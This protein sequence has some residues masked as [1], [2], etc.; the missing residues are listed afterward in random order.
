[1]AK[2]N[3]HFWIY[4]ITTL[5]VIYYLLK[6]IFESYANNWTISLIS[7]TILFFVNTISMFYTIAYNYT[8]YIIPSWIIN[9]VFIIY[10][11]YEHKLTL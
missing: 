10:L 2:F 6:K 7:F 1:M 11:L 5:V 8:K 4:I 3:Y 9:V